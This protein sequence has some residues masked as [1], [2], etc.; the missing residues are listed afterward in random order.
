MQYVSPVISL[1]LLLLINN[2]TDAIKRNMKEYEITYKITPG[3]GVA[4][5][6]E[7]PRMAAATPITEHQKV[8]SNTRDKIQIECCFSY[9]V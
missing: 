2:L 1:R 6:I 8:V 3:L 7:T 5:G 4:K 9:S